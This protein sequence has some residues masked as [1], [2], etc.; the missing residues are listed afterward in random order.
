MDV[1]E[2]GR[3]D[4]RQYTL[5]FQVWRPTPTM[6]TQEQAGSYISG[7]YNLVGN[8]RFTSISLSASAVQVTP[9]P[10]DYIAFRPGD[11]LGF[12]VEKARSSDSGV[13]AITSE[14]ATSEYVWYASVA[15]QNRPHCDGFGFVFNEPGR[16]L[17][18][19]IR[20]A[21][22]IEIETSKCN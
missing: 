7:H 22:I 21:P 6:P 14:S 18:T 8:N 11:V 16:A 10:Q 5:N 19:L 20:A 12:Y 4:Q 1:H 13:V 3:A 15:P 2:G 9:S 17:T